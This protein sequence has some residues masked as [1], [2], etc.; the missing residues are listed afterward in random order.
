MIII[1]FTPNPL[2]PLKGNRLFVE[3][4]VARCG[5]KVWTSILLPPP[6][7]QW[8]S[9]CWWCWTFETVPSYSYPLQPN[10][11][12]TFI[13]CLKIGVVGWE[14][15][16]VSTWLQWNPHTESTSC[17]CL[18]SWYLY[19]QQVS[20]IR[21]QIMCLLSATKMCHCGLW[22][23]YRRPWGHTSLPSH[24]TNADTHA[25]VIFSVCIHA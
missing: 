2:P 4:N 21:Y 8:I 12:I 17:I 3:I 15:G 13:T 14:L 16:L 1:W 11:L 7:L 23:V 22:K 6:P 18:A 10:R 24:S 19:L 25:S 9:F 5:Q 20:I